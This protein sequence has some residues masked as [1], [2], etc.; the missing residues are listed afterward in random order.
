MRTLA[1]LLLVVVS[2]GC[3]SN[4]EWFPE[5][6]AFNNNSTATVPVTAPGT[7]KGEIAFPSGV[8]WVSDIVYD[9]NTATFWML[10]WTIGGPPSPPNALVQI[11]AVTGGFIK[12]VNAVNWPI[13]ILDGSTM[14]YDGNSNF[15]ITSHGAK[16]GVVASEVYWIVGSGFNA[17][18]VSFFNCPATNTGFCQGLAWDSNTSS[19]WSAAS[20]F[21]R[22]VNYQVAENGGVSSAATYINLWSGSGLTDV[23]FDSATRQV[24]V[25]KNGVIV[26]QGSSG[27]GLG[28]ISFTVP[29]SGRGDWDGRYFWVVDNTS[30]SIKAL[31][32]R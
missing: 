22:L 3:G 2:S 31:F 29:G 19:Y 16:N 26:V 20:D 14:A 11:S 10:A 18:Y 25:I 8:K 27:R 30:K 23:S 24:F 1:L 15:W 17:T 4:I 32:V 12:T 21:A 5:G 6:S 28:T 7:V 13:T 9:R